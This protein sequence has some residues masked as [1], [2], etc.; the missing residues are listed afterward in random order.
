MVDRSPFVTVFAGFQHLGQ[1]F[2]SSMRASLRLVSEVQLLSQQITSF[3]CKDISWCPYIPHS[4]AGAAAGEV[5]ICVLSQ[6]VS[7]EVSI[8]AAS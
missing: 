3:S 6:Y 2:C 1:S 5:S 8:I 7:Q 4:D